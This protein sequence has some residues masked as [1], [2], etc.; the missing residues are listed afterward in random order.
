LDPTYLLDRNPTLSQL[1]VE[2]TTG[3]TED[4]GPLIRDRF[5]AQWVFT[6]TTNDHVS[7]VD[8]ARRSG[9]FDIVYEDKQ[10]RILHLRQTKGVPLPEADGDDSNG[11]TGNDNSP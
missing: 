2:I 8:N 9:W 4:A 6:D 3:E 5:G 10:C 11:D 7:F 1:Y